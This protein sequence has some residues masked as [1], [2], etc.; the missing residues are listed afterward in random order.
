MLRAILQ[1]YAPGLMNFEHILIIT[2]VA[3][4]TMLTRQIS[5][6]IINARVRL[7]FMLFS[8]SLAVYHAV[9]LFDVI[10]IIIVFMSFKFTFI[11]ESQ[12]HS[13]YS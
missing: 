1:L 3:P 4:Y 11:V 6:V 9:L 10:L 7:S 5:F 8:V 12:E 2:G 13:W